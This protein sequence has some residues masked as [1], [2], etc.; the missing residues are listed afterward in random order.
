MPGE[1]LRHS[2]TVAHHVDK[3]LSS[4]CSLLLLGFLSASA[5]TSRKLS[6]TTPTPAQQCNKDPYCQNC[7]RS[8][9]MKT[10]LTTSGA[11]NINIYCQRCVIMNRCL[12]KEV[13][14]MSQP[15]LQCLDLHTQCRMLLAAA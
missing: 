1:R 2:Q 11:T 9:T 5:Q 4:D 6:A 10:Y 13:I 7:T 8:R 15:M 12:V 3:L 14:M